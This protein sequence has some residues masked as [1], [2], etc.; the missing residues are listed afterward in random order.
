MSRGAVAAAELNRFTV[1]ARQMKKGKPAV[2][3]PPLRFV[4]LECSGY[5]LRFSSKT[6]VPAGLPSS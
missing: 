4:R 3:G 5:F 6:A 2:A 1:A